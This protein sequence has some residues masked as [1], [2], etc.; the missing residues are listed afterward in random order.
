MPT[1]AFHE[2]LGPMPLKIGNL[3]ARVERISRGGA[4]LGTAAMA[5]TAVTAVW[6]EGGAA[7]TGCLGA[8]PL[9]LARC[10]G[11]AVPPRT[12]CLGK[13]AQSA[14]DGVRGR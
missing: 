8:S 11:G 3:A 10:A 13:P 14:V 7:S 1:D 2:V 5:V 4:Q 6:R 12:L 9:Q